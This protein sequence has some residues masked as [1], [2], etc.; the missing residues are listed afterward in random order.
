MS[1][2]LATVP[3]GVLLHHGNHDP[4]TPAEPDWLAYEI[5]HAE[6]F[7]RGHFPGPGRPGGPR[8]PQKPMASKAEGTAG[9]LHVYRTNRPLQLLYV[10]GM[11]GG[12]TDMGTLDTQD[13]LLRGGMESA[14][15]GGPMNERQR[16][17][18]LCAL[19]KDWGLHGVI[20]M[21]AG[22]EI[23][24]CNFS[25]GMTEM[26]TLQRPMR[27]VRHRSFEQLRGIAE[28]Y[29]DIGSSR[30]IIDYS[31]MVS[32]FFF[33]INLTNPDRKRPDLPRLVGVAD[34]ELSAIKNHIG[35]VVQRRRNEPVRVVDWQGVSDM[36]TC[37]YADRLRSMANVS[38]IDEVAGTVHFLLD[39]YIDYSSDEPLR[40][41]HARCAEFYLHAITPDSA[42]DALIYEA[43]KQ[44]TSHICAALFKVR[45]LVGDGATL[46]EATAV[47]RSLTE[48]LAWARFKRC[49][50]CGVHE[51][52]VI[53]MWPGG[54]EEDYFHPRCHN[55]SDSRTG[56]SYWGRPPW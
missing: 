29:Y 53:P 54:D 32:A 3:E 15:G 6:E 41:A 39:T 35:E 13:L 50:G 19:C 26:Q 20:R 37:R 2:F 49:P 45:K 17:E 30:T 16:A 25:D 55:S 23:I 9:W 21:E 27:D 43:F 14:A 7:A 18:D 24:K 34:T 28:R 46:A 4:K 42:T 22:F 1:L 44:V 48:Y 38:S 11:S 47:V 40:D 10:D 5:E 12:K 56:N 8:K 33:P 36:I 51:V 31:S 52:C